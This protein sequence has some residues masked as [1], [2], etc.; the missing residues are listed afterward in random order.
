MRKFMMGANLFLIV[1]TFGLLWFYLEQIDTMHYLATA[2]NGELVSLD[3]GLTKAVLSGGAGMVVFYNYAV[4]SLC[5]LIPLN[6]WG[7]QNAKKASSV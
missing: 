5:L 7:F 1:A 6:L 3:L 2:S 4:Y